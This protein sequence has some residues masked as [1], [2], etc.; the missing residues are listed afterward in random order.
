MNKYLQIKNDIRNKIISGEYKPGEILPGENELITLYKSSKM[1]VKHA[2]DELV[3]EGL[4]IK[5][6][7]SGTFVKELNKI[8]LEKLKVSNQ[9][10][11]STA[12]FAGKKIKSDI[13]I[14]EVVPAGELL[15]EQL[16][17]D[18]GAKLYHVK[19]LRFI[20]KSPYVI[21]NTYMPIDIV[22]DL[23]LKICK[24]SLYEYIEEKLGLTI[25]SA[26]RR[27]TARKGDREES[28]LLEVEEGY[29]VVVSTQV[30][31]LSDG[32]AFE[33]SENIHRSDKFGFETVIIRKG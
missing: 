4:I 28:E 18:K 19:R 12:L 25:G 8:E 6:R 24:G 16:L 5:R 33:Y 14:F 10:Q 7:G 23:T 13:L 29:P 15:A 30:A 27:I 9:F 2:M 17:V 31:F 3:H 1:T 11:G 21:E 22:E 26:H 20:D 32:R